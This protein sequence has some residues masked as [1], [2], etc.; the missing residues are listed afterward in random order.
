MKPDA[1]CE[2]DAR[3]EAVRGKPELNGLDY[4]EIGD[5][6]S[7]LIVYFLGKAPKEF[8]KRQ[9]E[10]ANA[11]QRRVTRFW[12]VEGGTRIRGIHVQ[13]LSV[14]R[15]QDPELDD[16][17][18]LRVDESGDFSTYTLQLSGIDNIDP[19]YDHLD[20]NF[21][22]DCPSPFDCAEAAPC[23]PAVRDE[24]EIN[25]LAKDYAT[26]RQLILDRLALIMPDWHERHVP[27]LGIALIEVLSYAADYLS[28]YQDAVATESYLNTARQRISVRR[29]CRLV[30][31]TLH[32]VCAAR[33]WLQISTDTDLP[34]NL[35]DVYFITSV[36]ALTGIDRNLLT[37][38]DLRNIPA[39]AYETF[40]AARDQS[41]ELYAGHSEIHFYSWGERDCC[42]PRGA[43]AATL[44]DNAETSLNLKIGDTLLFE[45]VLGPRTG[46]SADADPKHRHV[47][48]LTKVT[49][50]SDP[51]N[52]QAI[53][54]IEWGAEDALQFALCISSISAAEAEPPC[55]YLE[56]VSIARG[57]VMLVDHGL[58]IEPCEEVGTVGITSTKT[59]CDCIDEPGEV[60]YVPERFEPQLA[61][62]PLAF[63][64]PLPEDSAE[65][66]ISARR[67][68][69]QDPRQALPEIELES[70]TTSPEG[71]NVVGWDEIEKHT[72]L[73]DLL[74][75]SGFGARCY[76]NGLPLQ[77]SALDDL[78]EAEAARKQ[79]QDALE[80]DSKNQKLKK[81]LAGATE[82]HEESLDATVSELV[83]RSAR[84]TAQVDLLE[85]G[86]DDR[87]F[88]VEIDN[89]GIAHLR[90]GDD[91]CGELPKSG[92]SFY[93]RYRVGGGKRGNVGAEAISQLVTRHETIT[94]ANLI[95]RNPL[96]ATGGVDAEL[97]A[98]AKLFAPTQFREE[99]QR[100]VIADDY[101]SLAEREAVNIQRAAAQLAWSG[102]WYEAEVAIDPTSDVRSPAQLFEIQ[103]LLERYRRIGH[104]LRTEWAELVPIDL[105]LDVCVLPDYL[106]GHVRAVLSGLFS[107]RVLPDGHRGFFHPDN[108]TFGEGIYLSQI[109]ALAQTVAGVESVRVTKLQRLF[110]APNY[111]LQ[112]GLLPLRALEVAQLANDPSFP[113][114][115]KLTLQ[116]RG[117]R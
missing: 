53:V 54:E 94:G 92:T 88:V 79:L 60:T 80:K 81:D 41:I 67:L 101:A 76:Q 37:P 17:V 95:V 14:T 113:E 11:Y 39:H 46:N 22:I 2:D 74:T 29:H 21:K 33:A 116:L 61:Q 50:G 36:R 75:K 38:D 9:G 111:E 5:D 18:T 32:E 106:R 99:L 105:T 83:E 59:I 25:Y 77:K 48:R 87:D 1:I 26:F 109:V 69:T 68:L 57:N 64:Q 13:S 24:P 47:V 108:L 15:N 6:E 23:P 85:S 104:D 52:E 45:E 20:F 31:Y 27:D 63:R 90:F 56:N 12:R 43:T 117:G 73:A 96:A 93:A 84:W 114:H 10:S 16:F 91:E 102:S 115:G 40:E 86:P 28:Y 65:R 49:P 7:T 19:F 82:R 97:I 44:Y 71:E 58:T 103:N 78:T 89:D 112:N 70:I 107:N 72:G 35:R 51:L 62:T 98:E 34:L 42:L 110:E 8:D 30:D 55:M 3:R 4:L 66:I 100:A